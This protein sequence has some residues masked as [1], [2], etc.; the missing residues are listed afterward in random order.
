VLSQFVRAETNLALDLAIKETGRTLIPV[1]IQDCDVTT[2]APLLRTY[3]WVDFAH[4]PAETAYAQL[5]QRLQ[6][7]SVTVADPLPPPKEDRRGRASQ[8]NV[9]QR[10]FPMLPVAALIVVVLAAIIILQILGHT[11]VGGN[12]SIHYSATAT[13]SKITPTTTAV[14]TTLLTLYTQQGQHVVSDPLNQAGSY[15]WD[16]FSRSG[17]YCTFTNG[18]YRA[19]ERNPGIYTQ[20]LLRNS[21]Y[22]N[23]LFQAKVQILGGDSGGLVFW[24]NKTTNIEYH[25]DITAS[26]DFDLVM[27]QL[28]SQN[29]LVSTQLVPPTLSNTIHTGFGAINILQV[30]THGS[31]VYLYVNGTPVDVWL[32]PKASSGAIGF[33]AYDNSRATTVVIQDADVWTAPAGQ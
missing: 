24:A 18:A 2:L 32:N 4:K 6:A 11:T 3:Q 16:T 17:G 1:L 20:C 13:P 19:E 7:G 28:T 26:G 33:L 22:G 14:S 25:F 5:R 15:P 8:P 10:T 30:L 21:D 31:V 27:F 23:I 9:P 29:N 12:F